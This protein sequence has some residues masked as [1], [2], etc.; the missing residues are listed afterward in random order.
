MSL[1][2]AVRSNDVKQL[3]AAL[4]AARDVNEL[5]EGGRTPLIEA[6]ANGAL[7]MVQRLIAAGAEP[8]WKDDDQET[9]LLK[10]AANGHAKV[11]A[12][13]EKFADDDERAMARSFLAAHGTAHA[14]EFQYDGSALKKKAIEVAARAANFV[15]HEEPLERLER[16][17]RAEANAK[18]K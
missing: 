15:G 18:K 10:A 5:G 6:A 1:I 9:A 2:E 8:N 13:L 4:K 7:E 17:G 11:V 3:E 14:P 12:A 16:M